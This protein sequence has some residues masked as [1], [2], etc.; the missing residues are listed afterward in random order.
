MN[1]EFINKLKSYVESL[2]KNISFVSMADEGKFII[3]NKATGIFYK[4]AYDESDNELKISTKNA[5]NY[6]EDTVTPFDEF[7]ENGQ[8]LYSS[9][10]NIFRS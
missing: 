8:K 6:F 10:K 7:V 4:L 9:M 2:D 3:K 1:L 5:E